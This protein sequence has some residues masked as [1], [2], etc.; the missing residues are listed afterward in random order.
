M[1][2]YESMSVD[3]Y[4]MRPYC[5]CCA[6]GVVRGKYK[7]SK[8]VRRRYSNKARRTSVKVSRRLRR[9]ARPDKN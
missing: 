6:G 7:H 3:W 5:P 1:F 9:E 4:G 2:Q 8:A